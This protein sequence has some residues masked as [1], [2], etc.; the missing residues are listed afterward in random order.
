LSYAT[1]DDV[2]LLGLSA[3]AFV[4]LPRPF[5]AVD[6]A[7]ATIR[8]RAHGL[9]ALDVITFEKSSGG[10]LPTGIT[11]FQAY[12]AVPLTADLFRVALNGVLITS[13][14][15]GG[16]GWGITVDPGR[17][18][19]AQLEAMAAEIDEDLTA[20]DPPI[21][22]DPTTLKYP[23]VLVS[24]NARMAARAAMISLEL[25][26][27]AYGVARD[28]LVEREEADNAMRLAWRNGKPI[29]PRPTDENL[30]ADNSAIA[31]AGLYADWLN[32]GTL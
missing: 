21:K 15:S 17:R 8:L 10:T 5:D 14:A 23:Q 29:Q 9:S 18:L 16:E 11:E 28:R 7:S 6:A 12:T 3:Q 30:V 22:R 31:T 27:E 25:E 1:R 2:Y 19:D 13:W 20:H 32:G 26:N 4:V 24:L